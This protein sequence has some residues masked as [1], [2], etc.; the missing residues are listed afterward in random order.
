VKK[1][2]LRCKPGNTDRVTQASL[3][4]VLFVSP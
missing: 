2:S 4:R 3:V 1:R